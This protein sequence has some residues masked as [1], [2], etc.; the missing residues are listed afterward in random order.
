MEVCLWPM[1]PV[2]FPVVFNNFE[3]I[4]DIIED[5]VNGTIVES[6]DGLKAFASRVEEL[7]LDNTLYMNM[8]TNAVLHIQKKF[9]KNY[10]VNQWL[11]LFGSIK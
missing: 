10:I 4:H 8:S 9:N 1:Y 6:K 7:A 5:G 2:L 3:A 11:E